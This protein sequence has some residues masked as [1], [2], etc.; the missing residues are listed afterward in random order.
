MFSFQEHLLQGYP[1][2]GVFS[3]HLVYVLKFRIFLNVFFFQKFRGNQPYERKLQSLLESSNA[4]AP[5]SMLTGRRYE[6]NCLVSGYTCLMMDCLLAV[7]QGYIQSLYAWSLE[8]FQHF[9]FTCMHFKG[10]CFLL[11]FIYAQHKKAR[12]FL[13]SSFMFSRFTSLKWKLLISCFFSNSFFQNFQLNVVVISMIQHVSS[14]VK[15]LYKQKL[16]LPFVNG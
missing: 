15:I 6:N 11:I 13:S 5:Y 9:K 10:I 14:I 7:L 16:Q 1:L 2:R 4:P 12:L 8:C 3:L